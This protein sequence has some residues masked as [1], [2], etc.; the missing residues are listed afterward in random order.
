MRFCD[1]QEMTIIGKT[2]GHANPP[3]ALSQQLV[4]ASAIILLE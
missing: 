4:R 1:Q 3:A 2:T